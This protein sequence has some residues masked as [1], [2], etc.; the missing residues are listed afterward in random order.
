MGASSSSAPN[1]AATSSRVPPF[2]EVGILEAIPETSTEC[3][4]Q[5]LPQSLASSN[6]LRDFWQNAMAM[7]PNAGWEH[8]KD[9]WLDGDASERRLRKAIALD[10]RGRDTT[11]TAVG[12]LPIQNFACKD[13]PKAGVPCIRSVGSGDD[14]R[15]GVLQSKKD[16]FDYFPNH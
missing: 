8:K 3:E 1:T 14:V 15:F 16:G 9:T 11:W 12:G 6:F 4:W 5:A 13:C 2:A 10:G 7:A